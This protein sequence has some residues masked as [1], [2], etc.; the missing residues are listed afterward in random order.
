MFEI[1]RS[2]VITESTEIMLLEGDANAG[3]AFIMRSSEAVD[4]GKDK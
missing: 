2:R 3:R 1:E 4:S